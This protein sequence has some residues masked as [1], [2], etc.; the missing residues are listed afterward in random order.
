MMLVL[1][2]ASFGELAIVVMILACDSEFDGDGVHCAHCWE[3]F[4]YLLLR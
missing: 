1:L 3:Y 4:K 2:G